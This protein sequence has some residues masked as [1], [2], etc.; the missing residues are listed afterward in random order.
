MTEK[1]Y[2]KSSK[3][4]IGKDNKY[5]KYQVLK[6]ENTSTLNFFLRKLPNESSL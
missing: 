3:N 4:S 2:I 6:H 5:S 1:N